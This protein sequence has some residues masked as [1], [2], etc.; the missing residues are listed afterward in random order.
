MALVGRR[1]EV[2]QNFDTSRAIIF[3]LAFF[4]LAEVVK[5]ELRPEDHGSPDFFTSKKYFNIFRSKRPRKYTAT[6][7]FFTFCLRYVYVVFTSIVCYFTVDLRF[8]TLN[9][10]L[11]LQCIYIRYTHFTLDLRRSYVISR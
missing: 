1:L 8:F 2:A 7:T 4:M 3:R 11:N 9:L 10:R 5:D 6:L